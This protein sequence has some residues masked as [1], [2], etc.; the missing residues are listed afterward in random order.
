MSSPPKGHSICTMLLLMQPVLNLTKFI[1]ALLVS[2]RYK[3]LQSFCMNPCF[4]M[5]NEDVYHPC[6]TIDI[7]QCFQV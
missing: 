6:D 3:L 1:A 5:L 2:I 7:I 4:P